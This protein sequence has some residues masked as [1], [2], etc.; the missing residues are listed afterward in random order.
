MFKR[1][2]RYI[3]FKKSDLDSEQLRILNNWK[4]TVTKQRFENGKDVLTAVIVESD[5]PEFE[6]TWDAIQTRMEGEL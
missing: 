6:P 5:W 3:V 2:D 1:E 4:R